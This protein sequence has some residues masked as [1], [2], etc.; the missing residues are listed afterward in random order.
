MKRELNVRITNDRVLTVNIP[1]LLF[2]ALNSA[3]I[4]LV[5]A[6]L[7]APGWAVYALFV[8]LFAMHL[9]VKF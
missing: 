4:I 1:A 2:V 6:I 9:E 8:V 5:M 3:L 7:D